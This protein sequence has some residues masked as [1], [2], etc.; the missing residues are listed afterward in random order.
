MV[1]MQVKVLKKV[2]NTEHVKRDIFIAAEKAVKNACDAIK[3]EAQRLIA[4]DEGY[5]RDHIEVGIHKVV[6]NFP[7]A[8]F[9]EHGTSPHWPPIDALKGWAERHGFEKPFLVAQSIAENGT[10]AQPFF[11]PACDVAKDV[12][13]WAR[14]ITL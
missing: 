5:G 4:V 6:A 3:E 1:E 7:Y 14:G 11:K 12:K 8:S 10:P 2:D 9:L 13:L